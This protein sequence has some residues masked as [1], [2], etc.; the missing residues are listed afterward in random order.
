MS[1]D[2]WR[3]RWSYVRSVATATRPVRYVSCAGRLSFPASR[4][5][6]RRNESSLLARLR[7]MTTGTG[8]SPRCQ[9]CWMRYQGGSIDLAWNLHLSCMFHS[10]FLSQAFCSAA[11][12]SPGPLLFSA[13]ITGPPPR[14]TPSSSPAPTR[15][16][17]RPASSAP[18]A[19]S[20]GSRSGRPEGTAKARNGTKARSDLARRHEASERAKGRS[21]G[22]QA[23]LPAPTFPFHR[24]SCSSLSSRFRIKIVSR[25]RFVSRFRSSRPFRTRGWADEP[26]FG[27]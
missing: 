5:T 10:S 25:F 23:T 4:A 22:L 15:P 20:S 18:S 21:G 1:G 6:R 26:D 7:G 19:N 27:V 14:T 24:I 13:T 9:S 11:S 17:S 2:R 8:A 16:P 12:G 3:G